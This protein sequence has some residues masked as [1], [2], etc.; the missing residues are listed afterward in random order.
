M[1]VFDSVPIEFESEPDRPSAPISYTT[2]QRSVAV[3]VD[4][5]FLVDF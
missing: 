1:F 4:T 5:L 3:T 2:I